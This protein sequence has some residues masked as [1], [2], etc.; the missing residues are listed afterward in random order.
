MQ[1][2]SSITAFYDSMI[3]DASLYDSR[4]AFQVSRNFDL[5]AQVLD[6]EVINI[7]NFLHRSSH[8]YHI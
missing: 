8:L 3:M 1:L 7:S 5:E 2:H 6:L 4:V